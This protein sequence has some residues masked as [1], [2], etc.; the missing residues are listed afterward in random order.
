MSFRP[1]ARGGWGAPAAT[2]A[3]DD[4]S[5][6]KEQTLLPSLS[7]RLVDEQRSPGLRQREVSRGDGVDGSRTACYGRFG[8][9]GWRICC[10]QGA[11]RCPGLLERGVSR[12]GGRRTSCAA[13]HATGGA[14]RQRLGAGGATERVGEVPECGRRWSTACTANNRWRRGSRHP[15][16]GGRT[17]RHSRLLPAQ[18][19]LVGDGTGA[20]G[21]AGRR[22]A[23]RVRAGR[24]SKS[25]TP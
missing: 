7:A 1:R 20:A 14:G 23:G 21:G 22:A 2:S 13:G 12:L 5:F 17:P 16:T 10:H 8:R 9:G 19:R 3:S 15:S 4:P 18:L 24:G 6:F 11:R 25:A